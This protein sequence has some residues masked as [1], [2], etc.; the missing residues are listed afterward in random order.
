MYPFLSEKIG[1]YVNCPNDIVINTSQ[2]SASLT[3]R[4]SGRMILYASAFIFTIYC[5]K[6]SNRFKA[7]AELSEKCTQRRNFLRCLFLCNCTRKCA[8]AYINSASVH[9]ITP[10]LRR[11]EGTSRVPSPF[12]SDADISPTLWG[13]LPRPTMALLIFCR[14][15]RPR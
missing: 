5:I 11:G 14:G 3:T 13:N 8:Y 10:Y 1:Q 6:N 9:I 7:V 2:R 15:R 12:V 4:F